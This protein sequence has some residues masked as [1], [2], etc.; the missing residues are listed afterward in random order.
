[1]KTREDFLPIAV[2]DISE[3]EVYEVVDALKSGW[4]S[5]GPK[6]KQFEEVM[7][8]FHQSEYAIAVSSATAALFLVAKALG[9]EEGDYVIVPTITWPSTANIVEQLGATPVF[10]DV[11]I[12][13]INTTP[14]IV[15]EKIKEYGDKIKLIIP[16]HISGLP[17]DIEGFQEISDE[18]NIPIV[19]DAAH[20]VFSEY[21]RKRVGSYGLASCFSFYAIKNIT[22]GD[23]G[24]IT[25]DNED[26][27]E[28]LKLWSYHG[29]DKDAWKRYSEESAS[30]HVQSIV[31]GYKFNL[32]DLQAA[33]GLA[34]MNRA[35]EL[36]S[37]RNELVEFYNELFEGYNPIE[38][39]VFQ[40]K[41]GKWG[42]HV[43]GIK[44]KDEN[45]DRDKMMNVLRAYNIGTNIHFYPVHQNYYYRKKYP[46]VE[47]PNAEWLGEHLI[48]LP[49]CTK[50]TKKDVEYVVDVVKYII[51][52]GLA[53]N[54]KDCNAQ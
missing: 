17:V 14:S 25:T 32:T 41:C 52:K 44:L 30:P 13:T 34:Q 50:H 45:I 49:L 12:H 21:K 36:L 3:Q 22:T 4:I 26:L 54:K 15:E 7:A 42:N 31:P 33:L 29:M 16:V 43:Y 5:V 47:L 53:T 35:D 40:T 2:P 11:D 1:M 9:I 10:V 39:P 20:A 27:Y 23:G 38:T 19:Y 6:V 37:K 46:E 28:K 48:S 8:E 18:Y 51:E 24:I